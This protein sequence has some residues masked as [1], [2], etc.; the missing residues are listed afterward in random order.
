MQDLLTASIEFAVI[1]SAL[2]FTAQFA[3]GLANRPSRPTQ[4][5][6]AVP[7]PAQKPT[8]VE[9]ANLTTEAEISQY[10]E[11][12]CNDSGDWVQPVEESVTVNV[13]SEPAFMDSV[14]P[15]VRPQPKVQANWASK[16]PYQLRTECQLRGIKW[17]NAGKNGKHLR[18]AEMI[19]ALEAV[20]GAIAS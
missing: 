8:I 12:A 7:T 3:L 5:P 1:G 6:E 13:D 14:V 20:G 11:E 2:F 17:R 18:K 19:A 4:Q 9:A 10:W 15:F 16:N